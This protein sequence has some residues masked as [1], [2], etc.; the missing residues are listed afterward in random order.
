MRL[1]GFGVKFLNRCCGSPEKAAWSFLLLLALAGLLV[2]TYRDLSS[3]LWR[4]EE[5]A[6][7]PW[8]TAVAFALIADRWR[9]VKLAPES[10]CPVFGSLWMA[11]GGVLYAVGRSQKIELLELGGCIPIIS[12]MIITLGG[13]Q[14]WRQMRTP[15]LFLLFSLPYPG[16]LIDGLTNSLKEWTSIGVEQLLHVA[17]YPVSR[18]GVILGLG[19]YRLLVADACSGLHSLIFLS[20]L[21]VLYIHLSSQ[22]TR[23]HQ[24][25]LLLAL[26]PIALVANFIRVL[27][28]MLITYHFGDAI[29]QSYWH[30]FTGLVLFV[31]AFFVLTGFDVLLWRLCPSPKV[32]TAPV[33]PITPAAIRSGAALASLVVLLASAI[34]ALLMAPVQSASTKLSRPDLENMIP[35]RINEWV[36]QDTR[37]TL[38]VAPDLEKSA[39]KIYAQTLNRLYVNSEGESVMLVIAYGG[40]QLG[41]EL[42]AHR[43]E[44]C[45]TAQGFTLQDLGDA[46]VA[47]SPVELPVRRF[48][49]RQSR[50]IEAVT[51][52]LKV[53]DIAVLP[54]LGRKLAQ[55]RYG[56]SGK[57]PDGILVRVSSLGRYTDKELLK[58]ADFIVALTG[59]VPQLAGY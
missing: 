44:Y 46:V 32:S 17:G 6:Y 34:G 31:S 3:Q 26:I 47:I 15:V 28:L 8:L 14:A 20:A 11:V 54:G 37:G 58:Q 19:P 12:G 53:G 39:S 36:A 5:H 59:A 38:L 27:A 30:D 21:G 29:G 33:P 35:Q 4:L 56:L 23:L 25:L 45:Y 2:P 10:A 9:Q 22:R 7:A 13:S 57:I 1:P 51:Y 24:R 43:Q 50:R 49:A 48:V 42:Q 55:L 52:W 41:S 16:W 18:S 40:N